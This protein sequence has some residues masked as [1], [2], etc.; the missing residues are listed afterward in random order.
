MSE[1]SIA[2][3]EESYAKTCTNLLHVE[4][5][6]NTLDQELVDLFLALRNQKFFEEHELEEV[7]KVQKLWSSLY[8]ES[9]RLKKEKLTISRQL[10]SAYSSEMKALYN[11]CVKS[12]KS[13]SSCYPVC[14]N[15][16]TQPTTTAITKQQPGHSCQESRTQG[17]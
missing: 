10:R 6:L 15:T 8:S 14:C 13:L 5:Q 12:D 16:T 3:L 9:M 2:D 11:T 17:H 7:D 4:K 1:L